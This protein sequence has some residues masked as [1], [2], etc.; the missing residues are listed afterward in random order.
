MTS[1]D[2]EFQTNFGILLSSAPGIREGNG[3]AV[4]D[5]RV[6]TR[7]LRA[8]LPIVMAGLPEEQREATSATLR[9]IGRALGG[10]RDADVSVKQLKA[11]ELRIP[12]AARAITTLRL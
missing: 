12:F 6:A 9:R 8:L 3:G 7:R 4:H 2:R 1:V 5:A 11:L 10:A